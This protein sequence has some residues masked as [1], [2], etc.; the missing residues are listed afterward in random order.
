YEPQNELEPFV[1]FTLD[2][3]TG[4]VLPKTL[5]GNFWF[6]LHYNLFGG[7]LGMYI[8]AIAG[9]FML[10]ALVSGIIIHRH[11]FKDFFTLRPDANGQRAW[12]DALNLFGVV[13]LP[14]HLLIAYTGL[15]IFVTFYMPAGLKV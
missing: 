4:E 15:A 2:P 1:S 5:G 6:T 11:I 9:M 3:Q 14:F 8:V 12:L 13:G 10:V 7:M